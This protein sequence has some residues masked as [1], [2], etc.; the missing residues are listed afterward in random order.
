M[1]T[2]LVAVVIGLL[3]ASVGSSAQETRTPAS[4]EQG[5]R[6]YES[7]RCATCH[8]V[9]GKGNRLFPLDGVGARLSAAEIRRWLTH[10][11]AMEDALPKKPAILMSSRKYDLNE[12]DLNALV[13]YLQSLKN[14]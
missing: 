1:S 13:S 4:I 5:K 10:T 9:D 7:Q 3:T 2:A 8:M 11:A 14:Q 6:I 12:R